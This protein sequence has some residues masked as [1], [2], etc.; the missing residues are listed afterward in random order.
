MIVFIYRI[1]WPVGIF[2]AAAIVKFEVQ[3]VHSLSCFNIICVD[4]SRS[5]P[6]ASWLIGFD[7][8][9]VTTELA[10][11]PPTATS[12]QPPAT[13]HRQITLLLYIAR[14]TFTDDA[15]GCSQDLGQGTLESKSNGTWSRLHPWLCVSGCRSG[16][17]LILYRYI[18]IYW[19]YKL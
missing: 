10:D 14:P 17:M 1:H 13:T 9:A 3:I 15:H 16:C 5:R 6:R 7:G 18:Y 11:W 12:R 2:Q 19:F 8:R 4:C